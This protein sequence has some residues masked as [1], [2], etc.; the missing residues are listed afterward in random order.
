MNKILAYLI[1][2]CNAGK[3]FDM[4]T[5][6]DEYVIYLNTPD[7]MLKGDGAVKWVEELRNRLYDMFMWI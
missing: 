6:A 7:Y 3:F 5:T 4:C 2:G 1:E